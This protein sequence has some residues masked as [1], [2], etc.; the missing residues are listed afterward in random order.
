MLT[1]QNGS[2]IDLYSGTLTTTVAVIRIRKQCTVIEGKK[3]CFN[4]A[5]KRLHMLADVIK[6]AAMENLEI[7]LFTMQ[8]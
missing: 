7:T 2:S 8:M 3:D 5:L 4:E 1:L 6:N